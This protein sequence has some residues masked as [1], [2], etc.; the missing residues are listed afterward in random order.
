[1]FYQQQQH[2][3]YKK[4]KAK[5][6]QCDE[7]AF[8]DL[9]LDPPMIEHVL[10]WFQEV[11]TNQTEEKKT[12]KT[13]MDVWTVGFLPDNLHDHR[14]TYQ[15]LQDDVELVERSDLYENENS[16]DNHSGI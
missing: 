1:M 10:W 14:Q 13:M 16:L 12:W 8:T 11:H 4:N 9:H 15:K 3:P 7:R 6:K 2:I 5:A